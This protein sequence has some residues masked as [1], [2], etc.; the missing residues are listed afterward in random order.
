MTEDQA[1]EF[2]KLINTLIE[3]IDGLAANLD[4]ANR[5]NEN[6]HRQTEQSLDKI[7]QKVTFMS[8]RSIKI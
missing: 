4:E 2:L 7:K 6:F 1:N 8:V 3:K 5:K